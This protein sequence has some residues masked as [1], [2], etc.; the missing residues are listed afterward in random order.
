MEI[1]IATHCIMVVNASSWN[2]CYLISLVCIL[3]HLS[4]SVFSAHLLLKIVMNATQDW[5]SG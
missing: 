5:V 2:Y 4:V 1:A 3:K